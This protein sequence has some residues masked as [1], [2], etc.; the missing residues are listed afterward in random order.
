MI[1]VDKKNPI[2]SAWRFTKPF[3][4]EGASQLCSWMTYYFTLLEFNSWPQWAAG[5]GFWVISLHQYV[6]VCA[7]WMRMWVLFT[8]AC[9][10]PGGALKASS[11]DDLNHSLIAC[12]D[13]RLLHPAA[14]VG[15][16]ISRTTWRK[17]GVMC[18]SVA[19]GDNHCFTVKSSH[20]IFLCVLKIANVKKDQFLMLTAVN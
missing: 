14:C 11:A 16:T 19:I 17:T 15:L 1:K 4:H 12:I 7:L 8:A 6:F 3:N 20:D 5:K 18:I 13:S 2:L 9:H 10:S